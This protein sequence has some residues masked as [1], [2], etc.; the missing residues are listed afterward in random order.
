VGELIEHGDD[1]SSVVRIGGANGEASVSLKVYQD[2]YHQVT[3]KTEEIRKRYTDNLLIDFS[4]I[5]QLHHKI[6]QLC[7]VHRVVARNETISIF[8]DQERK[9]QFTSFERFK[10]YNTNTASHTVSVVLQYSFSIIPGGLNKPQEYSV[11]VRLSSRIAE[12][13]EI[14]RDAPPFVEGGFFGFMAGP[15]A[16][17]RVS[18][19]DYVIARGFIEAF[20]EW[21]KG[22]RTTPTNKWI[23]ALQAKTNYFPD[24]GRQLTMIGIAYFALGAVSEFD[25]TKQETVVRF[26]IIYFTAFHALGYVGAHAF[27]M[28]AQVIDSHV[29]IS[30]LYLNKGDKKLIEDYSDRKTGRIIKS[31]GAAVVAVILGIVAA[32]LE[33]LV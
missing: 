14:E 6:L 32:K 4:E 12:I 31:V 8:H 28:A 26:F 16:E 27:K 19:V 2:I 1:G 29:E 15:T 33:R 18:Y 3:G 5:E 10:A 11:E 30:Y 13:Q 24:F 21:V 22:C 25:L 7:D 9:E 23:K 20:S 17:V